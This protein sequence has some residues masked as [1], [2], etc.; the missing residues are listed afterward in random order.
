MMPD[1]TQQ[2]H[3]P[4][5]LN[6]GSPKTYMVGGSVRDLMLGLS[7]VDYDLVVDGD[8]QILANHLARRINGSVVVLGGAGHPLFRVIGKNI[9]IDLCKMQGNDILTD[10]LARDFSINALACDLTTGRIIDPI[11]GRKDLTKHVIRMV[12]AEAF[13]QD[14]LRLLRAHRM[15][16]CLRF[17]IDDRTSQAIAHKVD[18]LQTVPGERIW[19]E[20]KQILATPSGPDQIVAM[21][22]NGL[23]AALFPELNPL[24]SCSQNGPHAFNVYDH[25]QNAYFALE[26]LLDD[27]TSYLNLQSIA[28]VL[29][30]PQ[31][32]RIILKLAVLLHDVGKPVT[33]SVD[34]KGKTHFYGH[35]SRGAEVAAQIARRL[36][37]AG[38]QSSL[39]EILIRRHQDPLQLYLAFLRS[40]KLSPKSRARFFFRCSEFSPL[41]LIHA[42]ADEM[43][44]ASVEPAN[45]RRSGF[46]A[47]INTLLEDFFKTVSPLQKKP[48]LLNGHDLMLHFN[49]SPSPTIGRLLK[50]VDLARFAGEVHNREEAMSL[51][52]EHLRKER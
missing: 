44:K 45:T 46:Y 14:P 9:D 4:D 49:L 32:T 11:E 24:K 35:A 47:F 37:L 36:R 42:L 29:Q 23:W 48:R 19:H 52:Q 8:P 38:R 1:F 20:L 26:K 10:L 50:K 30:I 17:Q 22:R 39:L 28:Y 16:A 51:V 15:A 12:R 5:F 25:S 3:L 27:P 7:P 2:M 13:D 31:E 41:L 40:G 43:G 21:S 18:L 6:I 34:A 33:R